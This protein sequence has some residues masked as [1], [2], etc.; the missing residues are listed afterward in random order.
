M[1]FIPD[2][3]SLKQLETIQIEGLR[4]TVKHAYDHSKTYRRKFDAAGVAPR[5]IQALGDIQKL[6]FT[7][8]E[9]LQQ[10]YQ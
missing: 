1:G 9:D 7:V 10:D 4:W 6:P 3:L 5:D 2:N 8:K